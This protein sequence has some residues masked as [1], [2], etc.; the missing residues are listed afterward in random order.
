[1]IR[2]LKESGSDTVQAVGPRFDLE[3]V[4]GAAVP[5]VRSIVARAAMVHSDP[6]PTIIRLGDETPAPLDA[7]GLDRM[8]EEFRAH[9]RGVHDASDFSFAVGVADLTLDVCLLGREFLVGRGAW[10]RTNDG[11][12]P[13]DLDSTPVIL[14]YHREGPLTPLSNRGKGLIAHSVRPY[15][16]HGVTVVWLPPAEDEQYFADIRFPHA[17]FGDGTGTIRVLRRP[18][19][20]KDGP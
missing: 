3:K 17:A 18:V 9:R 4:I 6:R 2:N 11:S 13:T 20:A 8:A 10:M 1:M 12:R 16:A 14:A 7:G 5:L 19:G 15:V